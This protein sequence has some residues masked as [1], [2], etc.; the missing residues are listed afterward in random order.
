V[1]KAGIQIHFEMVAQMLTL[2]NSFFDLSRKIL[3]QIANLPC[4]MNPVTVVRRKLI[5]HKLS[6]KHEANSTYNLYYAIIYNL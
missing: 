5:H 3:Q 6:C 1:Q 4:C 2:I